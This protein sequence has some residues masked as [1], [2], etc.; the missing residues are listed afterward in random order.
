MAHD[1][2]LFLL[3][4]CFGCVIG[5]AYT[6]WDVKRRLKLIMAALVDNP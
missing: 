6:Y 3:G 5:S 2:G 4:I 1:T